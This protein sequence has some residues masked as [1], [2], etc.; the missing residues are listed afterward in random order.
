MEAVGSSSMSV[1]NSWTTPYHSLEDNNSKLCCA[2]SPRP[3][4]PEQCYNYHVITEQHTPL[5]VWRCTLC[6]WTSQKLWAS[7]RLVFIEGWR[8]LCSAI[9]HIHKT[10]LDVVIAVVVVVVIVVVEV[11]NSCFSWPAVKLIETAWNH[12]QQICINIFSL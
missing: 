3:V 5:Y 2:I 1:T 11:F 8:I 4:T 9:V 12:R 7:R 6:I 10:G